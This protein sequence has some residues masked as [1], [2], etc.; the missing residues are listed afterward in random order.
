[1]VKDSELKKKKRLSMAKANEFRHIQPIEPA[2]IKK[3]IPSQATHFG[4]KLQAV[5]KK[6]K[7]KTMHHFAATARSAKLVKNYRQVSNI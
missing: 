5:K 1:M 6:L 3:K 4:R 7:L 2:P